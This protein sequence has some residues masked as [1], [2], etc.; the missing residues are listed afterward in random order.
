MQ[1]I[2]ESNKCYYVE[3]IIREESSVTEKNQ[4]E[5]DSF[6]FDTQTTP[7]IP[8]REVVKVAANSIKRTYQPEILNPSTYRFA[9]KENGDIFGT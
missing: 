8:G 7:N 6:I 2:K 3:N 9:I 1:G 5:T 4:T